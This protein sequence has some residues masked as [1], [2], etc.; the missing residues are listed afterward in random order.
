MNDRAFAC[1]TALLAGGVFPFLV[2]GVKTN[3]RCILQHGCFSRYA[4]SWDTTQCTTASDSKEGFALDYGTCVTYGGHNCTTIANQPCF[5]E[6]YYDE[7]NCVDECDT[8]YNTVDEGCDQ[9]PA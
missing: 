1:A 2:A 7:S 3:Y 4:C 8:F 9:N 5:K 6:V